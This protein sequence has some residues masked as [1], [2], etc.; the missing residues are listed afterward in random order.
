MARRRM[1]DP[2]IWTSE[3]FNNLIPVHR[4]LFVGLISHADDEGRHTLRTPKTLKA[5]IFPF[6]NGKL[7][8]EKSI[9]RGLTSMMEMGMIDI[10]G[11]DPRF[12]Q[13]KNWKGFQK[14]Q[15]PQKSRF[16]SHD[17]YDKNGKP[18]P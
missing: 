18:L 16:P 1:I 11:D 10:Y 5:K 9:E 12:I 15:H 6:D 3:D 4:L 2:E 14:I 8:A 13:L 17:D 7:Y